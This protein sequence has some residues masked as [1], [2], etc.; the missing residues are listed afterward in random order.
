[1]E[2]RVRFIF[3]FL[4]L[5]FIGVIV[6]LFYWQVIKAK[7]L[8]EAAKKQY[9]IG[10]KI[11]APRGN[12]LASDGSWLA[13][14]VNGFLTY[15]YLPDVEEQP[16]N[17]AEKLAPLFLPE[18]TER[19][20]LLEE[21]GRIETMLDKD[22][23]V[24]V[25]L[26]NKVDNN[27]KKNIESLKLSGIGF[28]LEEL[29]AY[30]EAS[31]AAHILGFLGKNEAGL[32]QGYFGLEGF[33]DLVLSGKPGFLTRE[34]DAKGI[35]IVLGDNQE[36]SAVEGVNLL[37]NIDKSVQLSVEDNLKKGIER[38]GAKAGTAIVMNPVTGAIVAMS[39]F[40][41]YDPEKYALYSD[42]LFKNP[43]ISDGF[44]PGSVFKVI[45]V[46][47]A[48]DAGVIEPD[49]VCDICSGPYKVDKYSIETWNNKY[50]PGSTMTDVIVHSDNV[51][52]VFV[53]NKLGRERMYEYLDKFGMGQLT[54]IDL[55]G[56]MSPALREKNNWN[57]VDLATASFGQGIAVTPIQ[58]I[59]A[60][61]A[62]A[63]GGE[64][65]T[66][67]VVDELV[68]ETW[69]EDVKPVKVA[70][71]ISEEAARNITGMMV[72]AAKNGESKWTH[73]GGFKV[74]GKTGTAQIPISGHY[75]ETKTIASFIGF[76]PFDNPKF[77]ML[78][79]LRE[80]ASSQWASET[81]APL[82][83]DIA[84]DLFMYYGIQP[85]RAD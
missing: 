16:K 25:P 4:T 57:I 66:P 53:A 9:Q 13:G 82:W 26:K 32:D 19:K 34:S 8:S 83:Y 29:R 71:I 36:I 64:M 23:V 56:E 5:A 77:V 46:A 3:I 6:R 11:T 78:V 75:D 39:S 33:Y 80:P 35:P 17:I 85:D 59:T 1:M 61:S 60:V 28:E 43:A 79:T 65:M 51:G 14:R 72:E 48:L 47:S 73:Q 52:M 58:L 62:I 49:T 68:G 27:S 40:P 74:A 55:Q 84:R 10:K 20:D 81:A 38:Y 67:Q 37:T 41:S 42:E 2:G 24:W 54:G 44:E 30:P 70:D 22:E 18:N 7:E 69:E 31:S 21:I 45:V 15:A 50:Y 63:N 76:A 12:I